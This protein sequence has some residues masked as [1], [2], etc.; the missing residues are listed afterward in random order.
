MSYLVLALGALLSLCGAFAIYA[1]IGIIQVERGWA[2]VI[3]GATALSSGIVTIALGIILHKLSGLHTLLKSGKGLTPMPRGAAENG[4]G[5]LRPEPGLAFNPETSMV[6][7]VGT[8]TAVVPPAASL[9]SWPQRPTRPNLAA[10]RSV[11]KPRGASPSARGTIE[12]DFAPPRHPIISRAAPGVSSDAME[13]P[14]E[15]ETQT[16]PASA[17]ETLAESASNAERQPELFDDDRAMEPPIETELQ[18]TRP[19]PGEPVTESG[20]REAWSAEAASIDAIFGEDHLV[21]PIPALDV[22]K[23]DALTSPDSIEAESSGL[24]PPFKS[25]TPPAEDPR[26]RSA[27]DA[28][29][30]GEAGLAIVGR[31]ETDGTTY[32]MYAGG[33]IEARSE[34]GVFHFKSMAEL[35]SFLESQK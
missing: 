17:T 10:A 23:E 22:W 13:P 34:R 9:R 12:P 35:K 28:P 1:G 4:A 15:E 19:G 26:Q 30:A 7:E 29:S 14:L 27:P 18:E 16:R 20:P 5:E 33:S 11:L 6:S 31:F 8:P 21:E 3:A 32:V 2:G 24:A 25:E